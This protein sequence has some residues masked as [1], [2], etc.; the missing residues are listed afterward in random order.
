MHIM[1]KSNEQLSKNKGGP[2]HYIG[3]KNLTWPMQNGRMLVEKELLNECFAL[4]LGNCQFK[5]FKRCYDPFAGSASWSLAAM[6]LNL[7]EEYI[8]NDSDEVLINILRLIRDDPKGV[9]SRYISLVSEYYHSIFKKDFFLQIINS[10]NEAKSLNEKSLL[11]PFIV[12]HSWG[13]MIFHD[14]EGNIV[15]RDVNIRGEIVS[16]GCLD[17]ASLSNEDFSEE[18]ERVA[19]L[20][21]INKVIFRSGD[22]L[23]ALSDIQAGDFVHLN[24]PYPETMRA[25]LQGVGMY[26]EL[27]EAED[28]YKNIVSI[29]QKME[30]SDVGYYL[31]Y[32]YHS[33][34]LKK[35]II[36]DEFNK[37]KHFF[38][39]S[40]QEDS[41]FGIGLEQ[42]YFSSKYFIPASLR[43]KIISAKDVLQDQELTAIEALATFKKVATDISH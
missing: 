4:I 20:L 7:A 18:I 33:P 10:Y 27:Y 24:P 14:N 12:N 37:L 32:G 25:R 35:F 30:N 19:H 26:R 16:E 5:K 36:K 29:I 23:H 22:F 34:Q 31:T 28:L 2:L 9:K 39:M 6:E 42:I 38:R 11:L 43:S 41:I 13:G 1:T 40:G 8:I 3:N 17:K 15:Y 21:K